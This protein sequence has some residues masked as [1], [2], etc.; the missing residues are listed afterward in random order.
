MDGTG[1]LCP[2]GG[3]PQGAEVDILRALQ[4]LRADTGEYDEV[5]LAGNTMREFED[6]FLCGMT[7]EE[8]KEKLGFDNIK[9]NKDGGYGLIELLTAS[10]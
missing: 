5:L 7:L 9:V 6:V 8:L 2:A 1:R 10:K 4:K 3:F